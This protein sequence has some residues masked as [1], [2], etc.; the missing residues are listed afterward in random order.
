M[1][2]CHQSCKPI[3]AIAQLSIVGRTQGQYQAALDRESIKHAKLCDT[4]ACYTWPH[5]QGLG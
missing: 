3:R 5:E 2:S 1:L 4:E